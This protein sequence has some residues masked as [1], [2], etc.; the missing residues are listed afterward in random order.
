MRKEAH[1][2]KRE[3]VLDAPYI[4]VMS[5]YSAAGSAA[6]PLT[7]MRGSIIQRHAREQRDKAPELLHNKAGHAQ[8]RVVQEIQDATDGRA[9]RVAAL[10]VDLCTRVQAS[11]AVA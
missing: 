1:T 3:D 8:R 2:C 6:A 11:V 7:Q 4:R 10:E 5:T 9:V